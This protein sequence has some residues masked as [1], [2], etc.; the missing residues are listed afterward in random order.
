MFI[1]K[2]VYSSSFGFDE[3][4]IYRK[5]PHIVP[6]SDRTFFL[7]LNVTSGILCATVYFFPTIL[8][9]FS[10]NLDRDKESL[11]KG[12][13]KLDSKK[14][15]WKNSKCSVKEELI[16]QKN[17]DFFKSNFCSPFIKDSIK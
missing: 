12:E 5:T 15:F 8:G 16:F 6:R 1:L 13:Q 10:H 11:I 14:F 2:V 9:P 3:L 4:L 17:F 7:F